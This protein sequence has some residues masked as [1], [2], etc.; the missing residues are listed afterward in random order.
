VFAGLQAVGLRCPDAMNEF[1]NHEDLLRK[2]Q[3]KRSEVE[4]FVSSEF[5]RKR[6]LVN[7]TLIG[8]T[9]STA[10]TA[11][12][13]VGGQPLTAWLTQ[14]FGLTSPSWRILCAAASISSVVATL[15][16]QLLKSN[17]VE[18]QVTR[19]MGCRAKLE[20]LEVGLE[21]GQIDLRQATAEYIR[22]VEETAFLQVRKT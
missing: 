12:P 22:C 6:R 5:P 13:A 10:L 14:S 17:N 18:E 20:V 8:G 11:L 15:S 7:M 1:E 16:T 3:Q 19:A 9:L 2:I 21:S 4:K